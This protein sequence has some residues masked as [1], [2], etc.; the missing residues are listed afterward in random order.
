MTLPKTPLHKTARNV[1][2]SAEG[3]ELLSALR[4]RTIERPIFPAPQADGH[5][6]AL[7]MALREGENNICRWLE[8]LIKT[9]PEQETPHD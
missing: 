3:Q 1:L 6:I 2:G 8:S 5:A 4:K 7:M 9:E